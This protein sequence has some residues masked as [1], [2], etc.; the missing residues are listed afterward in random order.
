MFNR[1]SSRRSPLKDFLTAQLQGVHA[2][3]IRFAVFFSSFLFELAGKTLERIGLKA[4]GPACG[5]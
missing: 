2:G 4:A 5:P 1:Y 3:M